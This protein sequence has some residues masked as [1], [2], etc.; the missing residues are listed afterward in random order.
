[1]FFNYR[2]MYATEEQRL[3]VHDRFIANHY[4]KQFNEETI[5]PKQ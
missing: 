1:M 4:L 2:S 3:Q 5:Q